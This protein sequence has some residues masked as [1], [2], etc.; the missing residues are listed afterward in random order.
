MAEQVLNSTRIDMFSN[1]HSANILINPVNCVGTMG[2]G[3]A[4]QFAEHYPLYALDYKERC[5]HGYVKPGMVS[6]YYLGNGKFAVTFPTKQHFRA[7]SKYSYISTGLQ[8]LK[9]ELDVIEL[10]YIQIAMPR[11]GCGLGGLDWSAV[12]PLIQNYLDDFHITYL[13]P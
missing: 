11:I 8:A 12:K 13:E 7:A 6:M 5:S 4:K 10:G 1:Q 3:L 9:N 2:K